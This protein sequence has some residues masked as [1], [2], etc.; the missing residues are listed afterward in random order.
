MPYDPDRHH[1]RSIRLRGYDYALAGGYFVTICTY[2]RECLL[3]TLLDGRMILSKY[4]SAVE[5]CWN[6]LPRHYGHVVLDEMVIMPNH[7][8]GIIILTPPDV[9]TS[10]VGAGFKPAPTESALADGERHGLSEI[11]RAL[12]TYSSRRINELRLTHGA[13]VWQRGFYDRIIRNDRELQ[14]IRR[15]IR[16]NADHWAEDPENPDSAAAA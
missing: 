16:S 15:Y 5:D 8:H 13:A 4:G 6:D 1:R 7:I 12:K 10:P 3:G 9:A 2:G 14:A 11:V